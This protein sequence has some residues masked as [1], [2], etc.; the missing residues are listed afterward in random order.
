MNNPD[1]V[2]IFLS[3]ILPS[4]IALLAGII[5][6]QIT[7]IWTLKPFLVPSDSFEVLKNVGSV[8]ALNVKIASLSER[9]PLSSSHKIVFNVLP[10]G[11]AISIAPGDSIKIDYARSGICN[12]TRQELFFFEYDDIEGRSYRG[13]FEG[14]LPR[15]DSGLIAHSKRVLKRNRI[16]SRDSFQPFEITLKRGAKRE[17]KDFKV[18]QDSFKMKFKRSRIR[19]LVL[20]VVPSK[21]KKV[22]RKLA[23]LK[24]VWEKI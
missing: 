24:K 6:P 5:S 9:D 23:R 18:R 15:G 17:L 1:P 7:R 13:I 11:E 10:I 2:T 4:L 19:S 21:M 20:S 3:Y 8:A 22:Y 14:I 12:V 16:L